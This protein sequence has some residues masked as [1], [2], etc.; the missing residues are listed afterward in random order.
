MKEVIRTNQAP[1]PIGPYSQAIKAG[2][3]LFGSGQIPIDP[4]TGEVVKGGIRE[5]TRRVMENIKAI[6][7]EAGF[8]MDDIVYVL[9]FLKDLTYFKEFN[10]EYAK[11]FGKAP[12]ARTTVQVA[13]LPK[14]AL[15][16]V[17]FIAYKE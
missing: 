8:T 7:E 13:D 9:V 1:L 3:F 11:Y 15:L 10:E 2:K 14:G 5:Q 12:P 16:E 4:R 6:V 17:S